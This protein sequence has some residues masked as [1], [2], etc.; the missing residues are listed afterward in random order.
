MDNTDM[1]EHGKDTVSVSIAFD[2]PTLDA[3]DDY[4]RANRRNRS[5][6]V[7]ELVLRA[8]GKP[9]AE[10]PDAQPDNQQG[11]RH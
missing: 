11:E 9:S 3:L 10:P 8:M 4:A 2:K 1:I 7:R 6:M 5:W